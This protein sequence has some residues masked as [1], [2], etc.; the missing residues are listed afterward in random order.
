MR[1]ITPPAGSGLSRSTPAVVSAAWLDP[2][3]RDGRAP[4]ARTGAPGATVSRSSAVGQRPHRSASQ[5]WPSSQASG[6]A[7]ARW[8]APTSGEPVRQRRGPATDRPGGWP[9]AAPARW[10]C[11]SVSPGIATSSG[12]SSI[13][14]VNGS[15]R[16]SSSTSEP[17]NA[18]RP[19]RIPIA[20]TQPKPVL[21][22]ERGDP[23]GD[24]H[25]RAA[26][27]QPSWV[28]EQRR[29]AVP[30]EPGPDPERQRDPRLDRAQVADRRAPRPGS[31]SRHRPGT[32]R[33][34]RPA[35]RTARW[36]ARPGCPPS[37][38]RSRRPAA[39][40]S[41]FPAPVAAT[42]IPSAPAA[43]GGLE[44]ASRPSPRRRDE[45]DPLGGPRSSARA[46]RP[47]RRGRRRTPSS[48]HPPERPA[49]RAAEGVERRRVHLDH[50]VGRLDRAAEARRRPRRHASSGAA[51]TR[52]ASRR[53]AG[54]SKP[55]ASDA[56]IAPVTTTGFAP[57]RTRS[58]A[59]RGLLDRV[60]ALDDDRA[61]DRRVGQRLAQHVAAIS[62]RSANVKWLAGVR[63][64]SIATTSAI[65]SR[66]GRRGRGSP[67]RRAS[68]R[69]RRRPGRSAC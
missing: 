66:P 13:R 38:A 50:V 51:A 6:S 1:R 28:G 3:A 49:V 62:N 24:E 16:V 41:V 7:S 54:P 32:R 25:R 21:A 63:P 4:T 18:T 2:A 31:T 20:S 42:T 58:Q 69:C 33:P 57:S 60:G 43:S 30:V 39:R 59:E 27:R 5:P 56:R 22:G 26:R 35:G 45:V 68:A 65:A 15:A 9:A 12:S 34:C 36:P 53:L 10:R 48:R 61:V 46:V 44:R 19:S 11:A 47:A 29:Q 64:R 52:T 40:R 23:A 55:A 17:A 37:I 67:H 8:A 14:S